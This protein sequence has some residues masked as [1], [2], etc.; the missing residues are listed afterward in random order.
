LQTGESPTAAV[1]SPPPLLDGITPPPPLLDS[2]PPLSGSSLDNLYLGEEATAAVSV[3]TGAD[4]S[5][6]IGKQR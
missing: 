6:T 3:P 2:S 5:R 1:A 4:K